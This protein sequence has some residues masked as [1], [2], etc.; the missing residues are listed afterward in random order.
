ME[1]FIAGNFF[2]GELFVDDKKSSFK[3]LGFKRLGF[4]QLVP[5]LW[6]RK[7]R[8]AKAKADSMS[9][10][11]NLAGDGYQ[12]GGVLVVGQGGAPTMLTY[13]QDD[14]ADHADNAAILEALGIQTPNA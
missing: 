2:A 11:G 1:E 12:T 6:S 3:Q 7:W 13:K 8:E 14:P 4:L 10:G 9:L 5:G